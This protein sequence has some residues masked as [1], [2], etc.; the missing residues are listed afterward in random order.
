M[1][2]KPSASSRFHF[3]LLG[4]FLTFINVINVVNCQ[5]DANTCIMS[6]KCGKGDYGPKPCAQT[7]SPARLSDQK[8][9]DLLKELCPSLAGKCRKPMCSFLFTKQYTRSKLMILCSPFKDGP[10]CCDAGQLKDM[11]T[12]IELILSFNKCAPCLN[13]FLDLFCQSTCSPN[14]TRFLKIT[15]TSPADSEWD[16]T[17]TKKQVDAFNYSIP[18]A[19]V[20]T[21]FSSCSKASSSALGS[22][23]L[24]FFPSKSGT[25]LLYTIQANSPFEI[26]FHFFDGNRTFHVVREIPGDDNSK[27]IPEDVPRNN[28]AADINFVDCDQPSRNNETCR[29][30]QCDKIQCPIVPG[31]IEP[32]T[33]TLLGIFSCSSLA[34][35]IVYILLLLLS[36]V[37]FVRYLRQRSKPGKH[38]CALLLGD[39]ICVSFKLIARSFLK[40]TKKTTKFWATMRKCRAAGV[41]ALEW[42][43][44]SVSF[45]NGGRVS[46]YAIRSS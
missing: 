12:N 46:A 20:N 41:S 29:C 16:K 7:S 36:V 10:I 22:L 23:F 8:D 37:F 4:L 30:A 26:D 1:N 31:V 14:Q 11:R 2:R 28:E 17:Q 9:L 6:G 15:K 3:V 24:D 5:Q 21:F 35:A 27:L 40:Q 39:L 45:S 13:N 44:F 42:N 25:E 18:L 19:G 32:T 43:H 34:I 38:R 33:C